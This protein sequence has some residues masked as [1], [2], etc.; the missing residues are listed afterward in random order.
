M[1]LEGLLA[2]GDLGQDWPF[3][4]SSRPRHY[5]QELTGMLSEACVEVGEIMSGNALLEPLTNVGYW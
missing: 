3:Y 5:R 4:R 2:G 1:D